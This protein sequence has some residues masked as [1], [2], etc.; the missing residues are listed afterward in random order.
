[1]SLG[2]RSRGETTDTG[3]HEKA[4]GVKHVTDVGLPL[5]VAEGFADG[6]AHRLEHHRALQQAPADVSGDRAG[7]PEARAPRG[8][9]R[10]SWTVELITGVA[11]V[12]VIFVVCVLVRIT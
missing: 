9:D 8:T 3:T 1:M 10:V 6:C 7:P 4:G 2:A 5:P 12:I 11:G